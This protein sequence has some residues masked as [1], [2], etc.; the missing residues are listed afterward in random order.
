[1]ACPSRSWCGR[2]DPFTLGVAGHSLIPSTLEQGGVVTVM[3]IWTVAAAR[4]GLM[5]MFVGPPKLPPM[6]GQNT[7]APPPASSAP[8]PAPTPVS[9]LPR[10]STAA[11]TTTTTAAAAPGT[12]PGTTTSAQERPAVP[13]PD[14]PGGPDPAG[15]KIEPPQPELTGPPPSPAQGKP[16]RGGSGASPAMGAR[17]PSDEDEAPARKLPPPLRPPY[18]G[19]GLFAAAGATFLVALT[20]QIAA[21]LIVKKRCIEPVAAQAKMTDPF[22]SQTDA[23][24]LGNA[25]LACAPGILPVVALRV[26]S[27][28]AL[29][30]TIGLATAGAVLRG[31]RDA[32]D[33]AFA[34]RKRAKISAL[35]GAGIGLLAGGAV[36]WITLSPAS[37]GVLAKC[38]TAR[39]AAA[40]RAMSFS[41]R[42]VGAV[43]VA[44]GVAMVGYAEGYRRHHER[45]TRERA[46]LWAPMIGRGFAGVSL[47]SRF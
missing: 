32:Y 37:W 40:A 8:A 44:A 7:E 6:P 38:T 30:A 34:S 46:M 28:L 11:P 3:A 33:D 20:E 22:D 21:H 15:A 42:D 14:D 12:G 29:A 23:E 10:A 13:L 39:C 5:A 47:S 35:R 27:D 17:L 25:V 19:V 4:V 36:V 24:Q 1:M 43:L 26:N 18:G 16:L 45:F 31:E 9:K 41:T 2:G